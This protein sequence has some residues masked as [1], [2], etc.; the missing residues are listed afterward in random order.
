[1]VPEPSR[2]PPRPPLI[3]CGGCDIENIADA[4]ETGPCYR[5]STL[6]ELRRAVGKPQS[7]VERGRKGG[8]QD[9]R[10]MRLAEE[11]KVVPFVSESGTEPMRFF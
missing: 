2:P 9:G 10:D 4:G 1:M 11:R 6:P 5:M 3:G 8:I 7:M